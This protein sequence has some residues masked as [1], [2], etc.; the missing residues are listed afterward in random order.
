[1][2]NV[3]WIR[4]LMT[5]DAR[6]DDDDDD[7][8]DDGRAVLPMGPLVIPLRRGKHFVRCSRRIFPLE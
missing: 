5:I 3:R 6:D 1:M 2:E 8:D 7:D 4:V